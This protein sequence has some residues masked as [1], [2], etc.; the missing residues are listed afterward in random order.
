[1]LLVIGAWFGGTG[2]HRLAAALTELKNQRVISIAGL[3][4]GSRPTKK[5]LSFFPDY[6]E[7]VPQ[8]DDFSRG[9][10]ESAVLNWTID[11]D[12]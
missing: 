4:P 9:I 5:P 3:T 10:W 6:P 2:T 1:M 12:P 8:P 7:A 11:L